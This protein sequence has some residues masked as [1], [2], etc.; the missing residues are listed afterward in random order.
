MSYDRYPKTS[1][2]SGFGSTYIVAGFAQK[3]HDFANSRP[4]LIGDKLHALMKQAARCLHRVTSFDESI[5]SM[6]NRIELRSDKDAHGMPRAR[7]VHSFDDDAVA[8]WRANLEYGQRFV[9][10]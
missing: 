1:Y 8:L 7:L 5:P 6:D 9:L 3:T 2:K 4:D 10:A